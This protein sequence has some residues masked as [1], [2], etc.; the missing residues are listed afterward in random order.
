MIPEIIQEHWQQ[1]DE[2]CRE[3][4]VHRLELFGSAATGK[5]DPDRSDIDF[6]VSFVPDATWRVREQ[7]H[8][9]LTRL[10]VR[11]V[12]LISDVEFPN[13]YFRQSVEGNR[14]HIWGEPRVSHNSNGAN[15]VRM[16]EHRALKYLWEIKQEI[17][18]LL[19]RVD[20]L[21]LDDVLSSDDLVRIVQMSLIRISE[22][23][24]HMADKSRDIAERITDYRGYISQRNRIVHEYYDINWEKVWNTV[25]QEYPLLLREV[26]G[27][28]AELDPR[29]GPH[30]SND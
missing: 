21:T 13:P 16:S 18:Y 6:L 17:E 9:Q 23:L 15:G 8:H 29:P 25:Q 28:M 2:L 1:L 4:H 24:N 26:E 5:W 14:T 3:H 22:A 27:L 7:L 20:G 30:H 11:D 19:D 10:F 12:D